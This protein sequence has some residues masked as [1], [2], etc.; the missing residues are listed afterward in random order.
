MAASHRWAIWCAVLAFAVVSDQAS[1]WWAA[2][3]LAYPEHPQIHLVSADEGGT[4]RAHWLAAKWGISQREAAGV[5][6]SHTLLG[7]PWPFSPSESYPF[8]DKDRPSGF[9]VQRSAWPPLHARRAD[10][11]LHRQMEGWLVRS[12]PDA[13]RAEIRAA[14]AEE[15]A[16]LTLAH[17]LADTMPGLSLAEASAL[18]GTQL[19]AFERSELP[20]VPETAVRP[21]EAYA[22]TILRQPIGE[23]FAQFTYTENYGAA[24]GLFSPLGG[25][26]AR[27]VLAFLALSTVMA[28]AL[29]LA[30]W[31][32]QWRTSTVVWTAV[33][34]GGA[35]GNSL[36]RLRIGA[37]VDFVDLY[38]G[39][40]HAPTF[41]LADVWVVL[42]VAFAGWQL[43]QHK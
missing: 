28:M 30:R 8:R 29:A 9:L 34:A 33:A 32:Q 37:V 26:G 42:G 35:L 19:F 5:I 41:N 38:W 10:L 1:K 7:H 14:V 3:A 15:L 20:L 24:G 16:P 22:V 12:C 23:G 13:E 31:G 4:P 17:W 25:H 18:D 21:G 43:L 39:P 6:R 11:A 40:A 2:S 27:W 36:D